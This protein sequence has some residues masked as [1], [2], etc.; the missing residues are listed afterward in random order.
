MTISPRRAYPPTENS[1][2]E[3]WFRTVNQRESASPL[4][5]GDGPGY[6]R[7]GIQIQSGLPSVPSFIRLKLTSSFTVIYLKLYVGISTHN[8]S[9]K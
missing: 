7:V 2:Q 4:S 5:P 3:W 1:R 6:Q 8:S 9:E